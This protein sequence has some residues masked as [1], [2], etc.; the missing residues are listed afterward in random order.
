MHTLKLGLR[1]ATCHLIKRMKTID[2]AKVITNRMLPIAFEHIE[3][4]KDMLKN[5]TPMDKLPSGFLQHD[6]P[7][8]PAVWNRQAELDYLRAV[9]KCLIPRIFHNEK[10]D[11]KI[12]FS[13]VREL[14]ACWVLLPL[15]DVISDPNLIN[16]M[17]VTATNKGST[18]KRAKG[19]GI[20]VEFLKNFVNISDDC[21]ISKDDLYL[22]DP[23]QLFYFMQFMKK[24]GAVDVL[25]FYLDVGK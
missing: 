9:A 11:S 16:L 21:K 19:S 2:A 10:F 17:I 23:N 8:H 13:L 22:T 6:R 5:G 15:L 18:L 24:Q 1:E 4:V 7:V 20:Q 25:R 12:F 14:L 3:V